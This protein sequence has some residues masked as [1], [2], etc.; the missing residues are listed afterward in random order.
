[1]R[2]HVI[3]DD[4]RAAFI[5]DV[6]WM[7]SCGEH[8]QRIARRMHLNVSAMEL[9]LRRWDRGDLAQVFN[10]EAGAVRRAGRQAAV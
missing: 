1:M 3:T 4:D 10:R 8:P 9:R 2:C 7:L 5:E 6:E